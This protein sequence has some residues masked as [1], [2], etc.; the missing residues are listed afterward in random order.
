MNLHFLAPQIVTTIRLI[1]SPFLFYSISEDYRVISFALLALIVLT[2]VLDGILARKLNAISNF[3]AYYD[4]TAD[5][6]AIILAY[7]AF[8]IK[9]IY[10]Y[11]LLVLFIVSFAFFIF[12]SKTDKLIYDPIGKYYGAALFISIGITIF[13]TK[14][15]MPL[16]ILIFLVVITIFSFA[17]RIYSLNRKL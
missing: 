16:I 3:G 2:D 1:C 4:V 11:W 17:S 6:I 8:A 5:F 13:Y 14:D 7:S 10:P 12:A 9:N 15:P